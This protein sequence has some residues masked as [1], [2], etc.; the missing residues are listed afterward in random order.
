MTQS[1]LYIIGCSLEIC[2]SNSVKAI[3]LAAI[4]LL[5]TVKVAGNYYR[6]RVSIVYSTSHCLFC[7]SFYTTLCESLFIL[8]HEIVITGMS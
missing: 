5:L 6:E 2:A 7:N 4:I 8:N 1:T 3:M